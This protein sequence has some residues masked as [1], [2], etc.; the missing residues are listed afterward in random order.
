MAYHQS[1]T[2]SRRFIS[3]IISL[4]MM[5][6]IGF[7]VRTDALGAGEFIVTKD[8]DSSFVGAYDTLEAAVDAV[9]DIG[10]SDKYTIEVLKN[11]VLSS[12]LSIKPSRNVTI[13]SGSTG[14]AIYTITQIGN[15]RHFVVLGGLTL[16]NIVLEGLGLSSG[17]IINGGIFLEAGALVMNDGAIIE[18]CYENQGSGGG[19]VRSLPTGTYTKLFIMNGGEIRNN[20]TS[21]YGGGVYLDS[22]TIFRMY[23]EAKIYGNSANV[24]SGY[25]GGVFTINGSTFEMYGGIISENKA[26]RGGGVLNQ[27]S[28]TMD[29][30]NSDGGTKPTIS[31]NQAIEWGGGVYNTS[32]FTMNDGII[33]ENEADLGGG[34]YNNSNTFRMNGGSIIDNK[35]SY[36]GGAF[37]EVKAS[38]VMNGGLVSKNEADFGGGVYNFGVV[39]IYTGME[40][41]KNKASSGGGV[42][43]QN[44]PFQTE[45][46]RMVMNGG[47]ISQ[48]VAT[49]GDGGGV[50]IRDG[51]FTLSNGTIMENEA[52][53]GDGGGV[54]AFADGTEAGIF[55]MAGGNIIQNTAAGDGGGIF[56]T[57]HNNYPANPNALT[58]Y[59]NIWITGGTFSGNTACISANYPSNWQDFN[60][61][62]TRKFNGQLLDNSNIN[63]HP[64]TGNTV[65]YKANSGTGADVVVNITDGQVYT[66]AANTFTRTGYTFT[67]WN[68]AANGT[69][70]AYAVGAQ[71]T[72]SGSLVLHA[73]WSANPHTVTYKA[74]SGTGTDVIVN[75]VYDQVYTVAAN[76]FTR[77]GYS[78]TGWNTTANGTGTAYAVG[79]QITISGSLVLYAQWSANPHTVTYKANGGT[80]VDVVA[81]VVYDQVYT[82]AA[83]TF[84]RTGYSFTGWNTAANGTGTAYAVGAQITISGNVELYAQ[85]NANPHTVTYKANGGTGADVVA[86]VVYDQVYT[87]TDNTFTAPSGKTFDKWN[88]AQDGKGTSFAPGDTIKINS[89]VVLYAQWKDSLPP[90]QIANAQGIPITAVTTVYRNSVTQYTCIINSDALPENLIWT[91]SNTSYAT[92]GAKTGIVTVK[93]YTGT[94][95]LTVTDTISGDSQILIIRII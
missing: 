57:L 90:L 5:A 2:L 83:N 31:G 16:S 88:T 45:I 79:A 9:N 60:N 50:Y 68:T 36:G 18:N 33:S 70:T 20:V 51:E 87:I 58:T 74:N 15:G 84:T 4:A 89:N 21:A 13:K 23:G 59:T 17:D 39:G 55:A 43:I 75:V 67:G 24:S 76:T 10:N 81:N 7:A 46:A 77:I 91:I 29:Y 64:Q 92:V 94:V 25:G 47:V 42:A 34:L 85:W 38:L 69:G 26:F 11:V 1:R 32:T 28:F 62:T 66:V 12:Q 54:Y 65:T 56:S 86:N 22:D 40:I 95:L 19:G 27:S 30:N 48:N 82:V 52:K 6:T 49:E 37:N 35:A 73:Q 78:F 41:S 61:R 14:N 93:S 80:G 71:I 8:L 72:I 3:L 44:K 53:M 63:Y